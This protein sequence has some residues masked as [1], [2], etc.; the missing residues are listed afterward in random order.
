MSNPGDD[1]PRKATKEDRD[2]LKMLLAVMLV[3]FVL[4]VLWTGYQD[5]VLLE[6]FTTAI[7][8]SILAGLGVLVFVWLT[9]LLDKRY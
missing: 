3:P 8:F 4:L 1:W 9:W 6:F 7:V 2:G 5:G